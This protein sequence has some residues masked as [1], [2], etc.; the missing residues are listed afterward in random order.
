MFL[1][2]GINKIT[3]LELD[4]EHFPTFQAKSAEKILVPIDYENNPTSFMKTLDPLFRNFE[5][6]TL[7]I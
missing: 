3:S 4:M 7:L 2:Q 1:I 5:L 6:L